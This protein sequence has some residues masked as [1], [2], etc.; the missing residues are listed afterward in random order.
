MSKAKIGTT[1]IFGLSVLIFLLRTV[2]NAQGHDRETSLTRDSRPGM[3]DV[4]GRDRKMND[5]EIGPMGRMPYRERLLS[6]SLGAVRYEPIH[7]AGPQPNPISLNSAQSWVRNYP[8]SAIIGSTEFK[9]NSITVDA[10]GNVYVTG[11]GGSGTAIDFVTIKYTASGDTV[12]VR[13][14]TFLGEASSDDKAVALAVDGS[15]NVYVTG[16]S[17]RSVSPA[18]RYDYATVKYNSSG[19]QQWVRRYSGVGG[20]NQPTALALDASGNV[21]VTGYS[22]D[23][24][25]ITGDDYATVKYDSAG[26]SLWAV[27][28]H[29]G[30]SGGDDRASAIGV[31]STGIVYV[32]GSG[33]IAS[34]FKSEYVTIRYNRSTGDTVWT[35]HYKQSTSDE[36]VA[37]DL[38]VDASGSAYVTGSSLKVLNDYD[39]A[40]V[41][42][43]SLGN[44]AWASRYDNSS[45]DEGFTLA[46]DG[47][48]NVYVAGWTLDSLTSY[49]YL[50]VKYNSAGTFQWANRYAG[51]GTL[52]D[53]VAQLVLDGS[54]N[55]NVTGTNNSH[56][57]TLQYNSS[58][59]QQ[60]VQT[61]IGPG[62]TFDAALSMAIS[63]SGQ[64]YVTGGSAAGN[65]S[66]FTTVKYEQATIS[67]SPTV[68]LEGPY[69]QSAGSMNTTLRS[70]GALASHFPGLFIPSKAVDSIT[71][72][73]RDSVSAASSTVRKFAPAWLL[74]DGS[75]RM[76]VDTTKAFVEFDA[77]AANYYIVIWHRNHLAVMSSSRV[78]IPASPSVGSYNFSTALSQAYLNGQK[79]I[80]TSPVRYGMVAGNVDGNTGVGASDIVQVRSSV[81]STGYIISDVDMNGGVGAS[82]I[83]LTRGNVGQ[84][85]QVP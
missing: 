24:T 39:A 11:Y 6:R 9:G 18:V 57:A 35:R 75:I 4:Q 20:D 80:D 58:G 17:L 41:K 72:E 53:A 77:P 44:Q 12:W 33:A 34:S 61:Y 74:S 59:V 47:S 62:A 52:S 64:V 30:I 32:T 8:S 37:Y 5:D 45:G 2:S 21:Y 81:G 60:W 51:P 14:Y 79:Q 38:A 84:I 83:V 65:G 56:F 40:T 73:I 16:F 10:T 71:V 42:Y 50:T 67:A 29:N 85:T 43:D 82:D 23:T 7:D 66:I 22:A 28:Y 55:V 69:N 68:Y 31:S 26:N 13:T 54:G 15:G 36:A 3:I 25:D 78:S 70:S 48:G 49:D 76:F 27:R 19:V 1:L 46:V 63:S